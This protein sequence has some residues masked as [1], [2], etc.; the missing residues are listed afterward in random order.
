M[1]QTGLMQRRYAGDLIKKK[2]K[3]INYDEVES[4]LTKMREKSEIY[5]ETALKS[6]DK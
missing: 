5:L 2:K 3:N 1:K 4:R 6:I